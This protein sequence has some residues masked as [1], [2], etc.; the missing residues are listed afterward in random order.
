MS[1]IDK[2]PGEPDNLISL[3]GR[4]RKQC[5]H[6]KFTVDEDLEIVECGLCGEKVNPYYVIR[7]L[8][9]EESRFVWR[10]KELSALK[11]KLEKK[12]RT[13]CQHCKQFTRVNP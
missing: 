7:R 4:R 5:F 1:D 13:K 2:I 8:A 12:T 9:S 11:T 6:S 10:Y 3:E